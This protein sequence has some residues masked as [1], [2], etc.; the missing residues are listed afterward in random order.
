[1]TES[2]IPPSKNNRVSN[3]TSTISTGSRTATRVEDEASRVVWRPSRLLAEAK[4]RYSARTDPL[5]ATTGR[6]SVSGDGGGVARVEATNLVPF[7]V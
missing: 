2:L 3:D 6:E 4:T 5:S 7:T 1:M